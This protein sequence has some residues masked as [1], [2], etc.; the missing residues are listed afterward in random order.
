MRTQKW[1]GHLWLKEGSGGGNR[2][3]LISVRQCESRLCG[4]LLDDEREVNK[5]HVALVGNVKYS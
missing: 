5:I 2:L 1:C 3:L 4:T